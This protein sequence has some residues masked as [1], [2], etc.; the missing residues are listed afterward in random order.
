MRR[1]TGPTNAFS[2]KAETLAHAV[3]MHFM[4]DNVARDHQTP[5]LTPVTA[6]CIADHAWTIDE[7]VGL[8][9]AT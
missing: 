5:K 7:I 1:F 9:H 8:L 4:Y 2:K 6:A 3:S